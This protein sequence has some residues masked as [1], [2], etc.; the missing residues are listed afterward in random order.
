VLLA[1][2]GPTGVDFLI[3]TAGHVT[4]RTF[5]AERFIKASQRIITRGSPAD[6][7]N[8]DAERLTM[9]DASTS[10]RETP[11]QGADIDCPSRDPTPYPRV[12][13]ERGQ[14]ANDM[15][16]ATA[17]TI[18]QRRSRLPWK[19]P[20]KLG[21]A[22]TAVFSILTTFPSRP[23]RQLSDPVNKVTPLSVACVI[24]P[25][26]RPDLD[27][28]ILTLRQ[29]GTRAQLLVLPETA[30][31][32]R[33]EGERAFVLDRIVGEVTEQYGTWVVVSMESPAAGHKHLNE[34]ALVGPHGI[35]GSYAKRSLFPCG[36][37]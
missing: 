34:I 17:N 13:D 35:V 14:V 10:L 8:N 24:P 27:Q 22:L 33:W 2:L 25:S 4:S 19:G 16:G 29:F 28:V 23:T 36:Y 9:P 6:D 26:S 11:S 37:N 5:Q 12:E 21:Y 1:H 31:S 3:G 32:L 30:L 18:K 15:R 20:R 7:S